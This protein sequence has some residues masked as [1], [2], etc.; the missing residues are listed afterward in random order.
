MLLLVVLHF[1][2]LAFVIERVIIGLVP[3]PICGN[4]FTHKDLLL[5]NIKQ[6]T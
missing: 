1:F 5:R 6:W 2:I 3:P 4:L